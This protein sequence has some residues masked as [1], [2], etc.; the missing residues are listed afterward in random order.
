MAMS[1]LVG[2]AKNASVSTTSLG[3]CSSGGCDGLH[4]GYHPISDADLIEA[5]MNTLKEG[6][7]TLSEDKKMLT[8]SFVC[9]NFKS[10]V[11]FINAAAEVAERSDVNHHPDLHLTQ[12]RNID[13]NIFTHAVGGLTKFDFHLA[14]EL[15]KIEVDYS[16]KWLKDSG[17]VTK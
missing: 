11:A 8:R 15:D 3:S 4:P 2:A 12:Y 7:W 6:Y 9:R 10:A 1:E 13:V 14:R 16:P 17:L 5:E